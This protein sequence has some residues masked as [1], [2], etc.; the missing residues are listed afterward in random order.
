MCAETKGHSVSQVQ[1]QPM[2]GYGKFR[3][4]RTVGH[5]QMHREMS[6]VKCPENKFPR[7]VTKSENP[8]VD[9][10]PGSLN[11]ITVI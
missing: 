4:G 9:P 8:V 3:I 5:P 1:I 10:N 11:E 6:E 7:A 2:E